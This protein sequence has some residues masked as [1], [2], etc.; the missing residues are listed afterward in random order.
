MNFFQ[1]QDIARRNTRRLVILLG[2]ATLTLIAITTLAFAVVMLGLNTN[3]YVS[4]TEQGLWP[5]IQSVLGWRSLSVIAL[6]VLTFVTLGGLFKMHQLRGGGRTVAEALGGKLIN[7]DS[8]TGPERQL[9]NVVEEMAIASGTPVPP[10]YLLEEQS[11][12]AFAA[13]HTPQDA[14]IGITRGAIEQLNRDELQ[15]VIAH[16]FSHILHGDMSLNIR[17]VGLLNG[18][19]VI[20]LLGH[21]ML[22]SAYFRAPRRSNRDNSHMAVLGLGVL[23]IVIGAIGTF[24]GN[25]IKA[26]VSRQRE[27][28]ADASAV[29]FTRNPDGIA[30]ALKKI[31]GTPMGSKLE[32]A[33]ASEFSHMYFGQGVGRSFNRMMATHPPVQERI[34]RLLP[35]WDGTLATTTAAAATGPSTS[36]ASPSISTDAIEQIS[37]FQGSAVNL[38]SIDASIN[39]IGQAMPEHL[40]RAQVLLASLD[41]QLRDAAHDTF[42]ARAV[43]FGLLLTD[44]EA[45]LTRQWKHLAEVT[46]TEDWPNLKPCI[47]AAQHTDP[48][49]RLPLLELALP[50][51]K[52]LSKSQYETFKQTVNYL[53]AADGRVSLMEWALSRIVFNQLEPRAPYRKALKLRDCQPECALVLSLIVHAGA[54]NAEE[55]RGS[56]QA[57]AAQLPFDDLQWIPRRDIQLSQLDQAVERLNNLR[58]LHKPALLKAISRSIFFDQ[59]VSAIEAELFRALADSLDCPVPPI[60][61]GQRS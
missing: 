30:G 37:G 58:P 11:I 56:F 52:Q 1:H 26:G 18:I 35:R 6:A 34:R 50:A 23:L 31:A 44:E 47:E 15:G 48:E 7:L 28:L 10:V 54:Q 33:D 5:T 29:Q 2:L 12:N 41:Q 4:Y 40:A 17:L 55:A 42:A 27:F 57:G 24:F 46:P 9:L 45:V 3:G 22:R 61:A 53:I 21:M 51:L 13:G 38:D 49:G 8:G 39:S 14:V 16:E 20:S 19:L 60:L 25:W 59:Q 43:V 36:A 32:A